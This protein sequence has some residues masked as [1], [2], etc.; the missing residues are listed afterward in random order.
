MI[1][2]NNIEKCFDSWIDVSVIPEKKRVDWTLNSKKAYPGI[3]YKWKTGHSF[4]FATFAFSYVN[5][6][7]VKPPF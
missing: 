4:P 3:L 5:R 7:K 1:R 6:T 2:K